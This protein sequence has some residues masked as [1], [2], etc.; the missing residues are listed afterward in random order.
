MKQL[1]VLA[2]CYVND[3]ISNLVAALVANLLMQKYK[4]KVKVKGMWFV[5]ALFADSRTHARLLAEYEY[6]FGNVQLIGV[7]H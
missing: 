5:T 6:G 3:L 7:M 1:K 4:I 2:K